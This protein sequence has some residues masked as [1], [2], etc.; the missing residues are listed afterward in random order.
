MVG[1]GEE[2]DCVH[3]HSANEA[4]RG[5]AGISESQTGGMMNVVKKW[6][7]RMKPCPQQQ[8]GQRTFCLGKG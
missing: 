4:R 5:Q 6:G 2:D 3:L 8:R 7:H 1:G